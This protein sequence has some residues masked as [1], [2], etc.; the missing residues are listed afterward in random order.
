MPEKLCTRCLHLMVYHSWWGPGCMA[1]VHKR[2]RRERRC[3]CE[4]RGVEQGERTPYQTRATRLANEVLDLLG[5]EG[6]RLDMSDAPREDDT[7]GTPHPSNQTQG[8]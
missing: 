1:I 4:A 3:G 5:D 2:G 7:P 8:D 6:R